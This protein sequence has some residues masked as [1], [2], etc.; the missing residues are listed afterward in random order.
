[1][2]AWLLGIH[3]TAVAAGRPPQPGSVPAC[4]AIADLLRRFPGV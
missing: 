2:Y 3:R 1:M 4:D